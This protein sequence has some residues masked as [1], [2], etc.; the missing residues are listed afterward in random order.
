MWV[1]APEVWIQDD[2]IAECD[3]GVREDELIGKV[4][5]AGF[6]FASHV[7]IVA[8]ALYFPN[9]KA[10]KMFFW[11]PE[12][13][14]KEQSDIVDYRLWKSEGYVITTPGDM[15]DIDY[16]VN[17]ISKIAK[18]YN[19]KNFAFDPYKMYH[20]IIQGLKNTGMDEILDEFPQ[21]IRNMSE[22]TKELERLILSKE[23]DLL[24][25]PVLRWMFKNVVLYR[26]PNGNIKLD[27][28]KSINKIDGVVAIVDALGGYMSESDNCKE[29]YTTHEFR[30]IKSIF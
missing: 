26:D 2:K 22:P 18:R 12:E 21:S 27:K 28:G 16:I 20:G 29:I 23:I 4:C 14:M 15:I 10:I 25:N 1:D 24:G 19:F 30:S 11:I 7:D 17:D 6:D 5:Y 9:E 8:L 3:L 13:K